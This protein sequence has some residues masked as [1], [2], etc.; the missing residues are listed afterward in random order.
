LVFTGLNKP[1]LPQYPSTSKEDK[2]FSKKYF[3]FDPYGA[4]VKRE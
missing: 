2:E 3:M 1:V 4:K